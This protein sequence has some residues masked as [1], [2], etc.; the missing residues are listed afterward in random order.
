MERQMERTAESALDLARG[1]LERVQVSWDEP[2]DWSDLSLY[3][4]YC[5]EACIVAAALYLEWDAPDSHRGKVEA[6]QRL[7][8]EHDLPDI[9]DL[10]VDL[11]DMRKY[12]AYGDVER[13]DN[14]SAEEVAAAIE[15]Y[16]GAVNVLIDW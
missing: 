14:L 10:L 4:F 9:A 12:E 3:G 6:A 2:T 13:P 7:S 15:E 5:V 1:H 11:N 8:E 16:F